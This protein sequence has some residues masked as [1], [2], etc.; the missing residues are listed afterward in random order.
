MSADLMAAWPQ[1]VEIRLVVDR[2]G[3]PKMVFCK[4]QAAGSKM[5]FSINPN[6]IGLVIFRLTVYCH[7][8]DKI[9]L[10]LSCKMLMIRMMYKPEISG[11]HWPCY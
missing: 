1:P 2:V 7:A 3:W 4:K 11:W 6:D 5:D 8:A 10:E 9:G